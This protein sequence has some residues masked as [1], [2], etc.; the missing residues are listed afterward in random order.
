MIR[1]VCYGLFGNAA[2]VLFVVVI[3]TGL[4]VFVDKQ[5]GHNAYKAFL[6]LGIMLFGGVMVS[7]FCQDTA[8]ISGGLWE[9]IQALYN[10]GVSGEG[11]GI[12][13]GGLCKLLVR[14]IAPAGT[15][16]L[17]ITAEVVLLILLTG[18]SVEALLRKI[19]SRMRTYTQEIASRAEREVEVEPPPLTPEEEAARREQ[20]RRRKERRM[21]KKTA[22]AY[23]DGYFGGDAEAPPERPAEAHAEH[24]AKEPKR[25]VLEEDGDFLDGLAPDIEEAGLARTRNCPLSWTA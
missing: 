11:G 24:A 4:N 6:V 2:A 22:A 3:L 12:L 9:N 13:G 10:S 1:L 19:G 7:L 8:F 16:I 25:F 15:W 18:I 20:K 14:V 5:A 21:D 17:A 23:F